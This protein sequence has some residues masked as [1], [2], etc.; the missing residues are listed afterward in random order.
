MKIFTSNIPRFNDSGIPS[1]H[2]GEHNRKVFLFIFL[3]ESG[4]QDISD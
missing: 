1:K 2:N 3:G 4:A